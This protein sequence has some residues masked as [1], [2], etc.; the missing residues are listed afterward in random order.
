MSRT[1]GAGGAPV[2]VMPA[3]PAP[4]ETECYRTIIDTARILGWKVAHFRPAQ[5]RRGHWQTPVAGDGAGFPD[6]VLVHPGAG[7]VWY[8]ELKADRGRLSRE[9]LDWGETLVRAG[10]MYRVVRVGE[11]RAFLQDLADGALR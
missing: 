11:L 1:F 4:T 9:Q 8:V 10:A 2:K 7:H 5:N 3:P 6:F